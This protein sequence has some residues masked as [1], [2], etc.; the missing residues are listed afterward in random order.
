[1]KPS[2][3][4][5]L[6]LQAAARLEAFFA[7]D[8]NQA[9]KTLTPR[10][11]E[12]YHHWFQQDS[13]VFSRLMLYR[14]DRLGSILNC[15]DFAGWRVF[16]AGAGYGK[17]A[18]MLAL[19]GASKVVAVDILPGRI[20]DLTRLAHVA[21]LEAVVPICGDYK[22][23]MN[24]HGPYDL[25]LANFFLSH[26]NS[27]GTF[28][29]L[30]HKQLAPGGILYLSD[31]NNGLS[32]S[33]QISVRREWWASEYAGILDRQKGHFL[34]Q[35]RAAVDAVLPSMPSARRWLV[36]EWCAWATRGM[37]I[38]EVQ[39]YGRWFLDRHQPRPPKPPF[40]YR[41][42]KTGVPEER[43]LNPFKIVAALRKRGFDVNLF[44]IVGSDDGGW[45]QAK[46][47]WL[48]RALAP[49]FHIVAVRRE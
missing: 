37:T 15:R 22:E 42:P 17:A 8:G 1:M 5:H 48:R 16:D 47:A 45:L 10:F 20:H 11:F 39:A 36:R 4:L 34:Q 41:D 7:S 6:N 12:K 49:T 32:P 40:P 14:L 31:D 23:A 3:Y 38:A 13:P 9:R 30:C 46:T 18:L 24:E 25:V 19:G 35:R 26:I 2:P 29:D 28:F 33:R 43:L 44:P 21:G 27:F